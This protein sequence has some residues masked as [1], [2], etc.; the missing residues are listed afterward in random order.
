MNMK[1]LKKI[2]EKLDNITQFGQERYIGKC[3]GSWF[4]IIYCSGEVP[5]SKMYNPLF[6]S[7]VGYMKKNCTIKKKIFCGLTDPVVTIIQLVFSY[8]IFEIVLS[9]VMLSIFL[10]VVWCGGVGILTY[11]FSKYTEIGK[12]RIAKLEEFFEKI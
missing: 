2:E 7:A 8:I 11:F 12:I 1:P 4:Y 6:Y 10:A 5:F 9:D 3:I